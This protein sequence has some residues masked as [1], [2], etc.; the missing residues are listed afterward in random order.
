MVACCSRFAD[1]SLEA[2]A[3][4][5]P[6]WFTLGTA[7]SR[8][9][10]GGIPQLTHWLRERVMNASSIDLRPQLL[11]GLIRRIDEAGGAL[12]DAQTAVR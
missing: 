2:K 8:W 3:I 4:L 1:N 9:K 10:M 7:W 11:D 6:W 12:H 5:L